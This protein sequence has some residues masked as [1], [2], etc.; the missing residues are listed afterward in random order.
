MECGDEGKL[1]ANVQDD[2]WTKVLEAIDQ[3]QMDSFTHVPKTWVV[4]TGS[5]RETQEM[6]HGNKGRTKTVCHNKEAE[7]ST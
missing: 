3:R 5:Q 6:E 1:K 4:A 2:I 7:Q